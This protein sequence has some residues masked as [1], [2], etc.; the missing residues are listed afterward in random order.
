MSNYSEQ[1]K[2]QT[3][4]E[5]SDDSQGN[6]SELDLMDDLQKPQANKE[7]KADQEQVDDPKNQTRAVE[8]SDG[9]SKQDNTTLESSDG[10]STGNLELAFDDEIFGDV[11]KKIKDYV[12]KS[13]QEDLDKNI[14]ISEHQIFNDFFKLME[15]HER[16]L[17]SE[18]LS[19]VE[20]GIT[21]FL[22][23]TDNINPRSL[24][25]AHEIS[26]RKEIVYSFF[27]LFNLSIIQKFLKN[28]PIPNQLEIPYR[29]C[30][31]RI[32]VVMRKVAVYL[33]MGL[34]DEQRPSNVLEMISLLLNHVK[35]NLKTSDLS[36]N[37]DYT[38]PSV[39]RYY[40]LL[41]VW[42]FAHK[43]VLVPDLIA[44]GCIEVI[45]DGLTIIS[46]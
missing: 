24:F 19:E 40:I 32:L 45:M 33:D 6:Q 36:L 18:N 25:A 22:E 31:T 44:A 38:D 46:E 23:A 3:G 14:L 12:E 26:A 4:T 9:T 29:F 30:I 7:T 27:N 42:E 2:I 13:T 37:P 17:T 21:V 8:L 43:T 20:K 15:K 5:I 16:S 10:E 34:S 39:T 35:T 28:G 41:L 11:F 1:A